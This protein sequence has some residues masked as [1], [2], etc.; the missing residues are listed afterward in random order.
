[1]CWVILG[2]HRCPRIHCDLHYMHGMQTYL[3]TLNQ[4]GVGWRWLMVRWG[5]PS[6]LSSHLSLRHDW[7][8]VV[9][10][11][12]YLRMMGGGMAKMP[13]KIKWVKVSDFLS[14][15]VSSWTTVTA[16]PVFLTTRSEHVV[17]RLRSIVTNK[18]LGQEPGPFLSPRRPDLV[19]LF[20]DF[21]YLKISPK[22]Q[23]VLL[24]KN[25]ILSFY[26]YPSTHKKSAATKIT[27]SH[28][29]R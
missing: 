12:T 15:V 14:S 27:H 13:F 7:F 6:P 23:T 28:K 26:S 16:S 4:A 20:M 24:R 2:T 9:W 18:G 11:S 22:K 3:W 10:F 29:P 5:D 17:C 19:L 25:Q 1:M 21:I 8:C